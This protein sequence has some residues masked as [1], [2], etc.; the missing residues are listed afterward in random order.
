MPTLI[1]PTYQIIDSESC[2]II[3]TAHQ[4]SSI[5]K[6]HKKHQQST[7]V[8]ELLRWVQAELSLVAPLIE[9]A[10]PYYFIHDDRRYF[11]G[12]SHSQ[13]SI[14]L[15]VSHQPCA[16][17]IELRNIAWQVAARFF[18][19]NE[20]AILQG[21]ATDEQPTLINA[22]WRLKECW[23]KLNRG[24]LTHGLGVDFG[25]LIPQ[26]MTDDDF[27]YQDWRIY[28]DNTCRLTAIHLLD[29]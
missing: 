7:A 1:N 18:H 27:D 25:E 21:F 20:L 22:L 26:L 3:A 15:I 16:I 9:I 24:T 10:F 5:P 2:T 13:D 19:P 14:A 29:R 6:T 4:S 12:F 28:H 11:V 17:D 8:R 23:I